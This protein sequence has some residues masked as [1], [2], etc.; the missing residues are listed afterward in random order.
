MR[1]LEP[2]P[3]LRQVRKD[4]VVVAGAVGAH[5]QTGGGGAAH[6]QG[7]LS[8]DS[9]LAHQLARRSE[10]GAGSRILEEALLRRAPPARL[11]LLELPCGVVQE[12]AGERIEPDKKEQVQP[13][14]VMQLA[15]PE[16]ENARERAGPGPGGSLITDRRHTRFPQKRT[17][18][19]RSAPDRCTA[20]PAGRSTGR[21]RS[22]S[23]TES[24]TRWHR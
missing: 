23:G 13:D 11:E 17:L 5:F 3:A 24:G 7:Y 21:Y 20:R 16:L 10:I 8:A 18:R 22:P 9:E 4:D 19:P 14:V 12:Q 15:V 2:G 6:G 1:G